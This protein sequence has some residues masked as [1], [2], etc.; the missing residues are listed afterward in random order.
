MQ[1]A[2]TECVE[3]K[4]GH[5]HPEL[6]IV[7][8]L[9]D[10]GKPVK[11][12]IPGEVTIT[13]LGIEGMPLLRYRTGDVAA[14]YNEPCGCKRNTLRLGPVVG[15]KQQMI[16]LKG[17]TIYPQGIFEIMHA[18]E[19][20]LDYVIETF[21]GNLGTDELNLHVHVKDD[22]RLTVEKYLKS[23]FQSR[24]RVVPNISFSD[25]LELEKIQL[26]G[27]SRKIKKFID[28]RQVY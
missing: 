14:Y 23:V 2:F 7:E 4:G 16:K 11:A 8:V 27:Q 6:I 9:D 1:T 24:L 5:H 18:T 10:N 25:Q 28:N 12:G 19:H 26:S 3:G 17:T 21:T 15:R 20:I 22:N 13:T